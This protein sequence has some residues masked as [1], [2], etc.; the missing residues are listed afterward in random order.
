M[1]LE[2]E[3]SKGKFLKHKLD[4]DGKTTGSKNENPILDKR[5]YE[6]QLP[7]GE[8]NTYTANTIAENGDELLIQRAMKASI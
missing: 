7:N 4:K 1:P 3:L 5:H 8:I 6:V 2:G